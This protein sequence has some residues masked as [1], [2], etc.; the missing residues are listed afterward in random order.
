MAKTTG[1]GARRNTRRAAPSANEL[2]NS[3]G[4]QV[5]GNDF[6]GAV[7]AASKGEFNKIT[8][9]MYD[10]METMDRYYG[11]N[12]YNNLAATMKKDGSTGKFTSFNQDTSRSRAFYEVIDLN[13]DLDLPSN[14]RVP[15]Y[16][17]PQSEED[18]SPADLTVVP[19]STTN[20]QRPRTVAAGYDEEEEKLT[21]MFRDGTLY[22]YY[23]VDKN[24]WKAFKANRSKGAIIAQMLDYKPR[25]EADSI[26][27]K[28]Q[29]AFYR[30]SRGAQI[31]VKGT[32]RGQ[33][34]VIFKTEGQSK[35]TAKASG[36][37]PS[38]GGK[39]PKRK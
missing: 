27:D 38:K 28:A 22:N 33:N 6:K 1:G 14:L 3:L 8:D 16:K 29:Q 7:T 5:F 11:P 20:Y 39:A 37:N 35:R 23:E 25:G 24:E 18:S 2:L 21:V 34:K 26:S 15:G 12:S 32:V 13:T 4:K 9:V 30:F 10:D 19:T 31:H 36:K 17:G